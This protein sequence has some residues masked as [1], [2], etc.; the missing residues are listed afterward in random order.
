MGSNC[1]FIYSHM[2]KSKGC[3]MLTS[4]YCLECFDARVIFNCPVVRLEWEYHL[5]WGPLFLFHLDFYHL[6]S[7]Q[8]EQH[9]VSYTK[10]KLSAVDII[11]IY[12]FMLGAL[13][14]VDGTRCV[15]YGCTQHG[16]RMT[17]HR[18][19]RFVDYQP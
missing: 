16:R 9:I 4:I 15:Q 13:I 11:H 17:R 8:Q 12:V 10:S 14:N 1:V 6:H 19:V 3:L 7:I 18:S 2:N 5:H